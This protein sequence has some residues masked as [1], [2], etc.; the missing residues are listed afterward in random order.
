[1]TD[2][3]LADQRTAYLTLL[4]RHMTEHRL[5]DTVSLIKLPHDSYDTGAVELYPWNTTDLA[6]F[7]AWLRSL[8]GPTVTVW[9]LS[10]Q[11]ARCVHVMAVGGLDDGTATQ[12]RVIVE[13]DEFDL[14]AV[15]T[16]LAKDAEIP[17]ELML[18][19][20]SAE[21]AEASVDESAM[22]GAS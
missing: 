17:V 11:F 19:L 6:V 15:N 2:T 18:S 3:I 16:P 5:V 10:K 8:R 7:A 12:V 22:A 20:V 9:A 4:L 1:M 14:L 13:D 21:A